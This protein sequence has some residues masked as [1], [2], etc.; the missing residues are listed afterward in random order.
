MA[1]FRGTEELEKC[2]VRERQE[3][4][5]SEAVRS[6]LPGDERWSIH[7]Y[8]LYGAV[9]SATLKLDEFRYGNDRPENPTLADVVRLGERF[10]PEPLT[11]V[12]D[13][14]LS[15]RPTEYC[16]G[17]PEDKKQ[18]WAEEIPVSPFL[19]WVD[20]FSGNK[21]AFKWWTRLPVGL[22]EIRVEVVLHGSN[23]G[24]YDTQWKDY[25][26]T[27]RVERCSFNRDIERTQTIMRDGEPLAEHTGTIKW[28]TGDPWNQ[29]YQN[30]F[31][32]YWVDLRNDMTASVADL[33]RQLI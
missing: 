33:A 32:L 20:G 2:H 5:L 26:V 31:T 21:V 17:L 11:M 4:E 25:Q 15:F 22:V 28:G 12:R 7:P 6:E 13:G 23:L 18:R 10:A 14:S 24:R 30:D 3:L 29:K 1:R 9:A 16:D 27:R 8:R 19:A